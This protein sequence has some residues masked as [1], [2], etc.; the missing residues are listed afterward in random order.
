MTSVW[1]IGPALER[2]VSASVWANAIGSGSY[3]DSSWDVTNGWSLP[4]A[5]F[6]TAQLNLLANDSEFLL[7]QADGSRVL[8][9]VSPQTK[10]TALSYYQ[11]VKTLAAQASNSASSRLVNIGDNGLGTNLLANAVSTSGTSR[12]YW[13]VG[14]GVTGIALAWRHWYTDLTNPKS[15]KDPGGSIVFSASVEVIS[16]TNPG[17]SAGTIYRL[18]FG[19][20]TQATLDPG[21]RITCDLLGLSLLPGDVIAVRTFLVSG[22]AYAPRKTWG[23]GDG[24]FTLLPI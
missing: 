6:S 14:V 18:T 20:K 24:G 21:A 5:G 4:Q 1:Y 7:G 8:T 15:D 9:T 2:L 10:D 23:A 22:T 16:S 17:T 3:V 19:G 11:A 12:H 13:I